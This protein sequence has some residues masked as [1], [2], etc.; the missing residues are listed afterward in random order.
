VLDGRKR[1]EIL[2][3][4]LGEL[5]DE[6]L[7]EYG[8]CKDDYFRKVLLKVKPVPGVV[9]FVRGLQNAHIAMGVATSASKSRTRHSLQRLHL[10]TE[11]RAVVTGDDVTVG[12]PHPSIYN[13]ACERL[14]VAPKY[15]LAIEDAVS[16]IQAARAAGLTCIG[17]AGHQSPTRL[18]EAGA[19]HVVDDF[20]DLSVAQLECFLLNHHHAI[21]T[22]STPVRGLTVSS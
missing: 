8:K 17:V 6:E 9:E 4:F 22:G 5:S 13:L 7:Q 3:H 12:K 21:A 20:L 16:G 14:N 1:N 19:A 18:R 2:R 10:I 11:F 15:T